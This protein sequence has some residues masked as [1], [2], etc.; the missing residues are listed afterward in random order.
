MAAGK[1]TKSSSRLGQS[2][3]LSGFLLFS[4]VNC[5]LAQLGSNP[6]DAPTER[7]SLSILPELERGIV[8]AGAI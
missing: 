5:T 8:G 4:K 2:G 7:Q 6:V 3:T 1:D